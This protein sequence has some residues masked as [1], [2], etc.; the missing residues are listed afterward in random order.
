LPCAACSSLVFASR[1]SAPGWAGAVAATA[2]H[3]TAPHAQ[4]AEH[5][6]AGDRTATAGGS[7]HPAVASRCKCLPSLVVAWDGADENASGS[8]LAGDP[9]QFLADPHAASRSEASPITKI[10]ATLTA[11]AA[12]L[13]SLRRPRCALLLCSARSAPLRSAQGVLSAPL[14]SPARGQREREPNSLL[15]ANQRSSH[16]RSTRLTSTFAYPPPSPSTPSVQP[17]SVRILGRVP[18][19]SLKILQKGLVLAA[20]APGTRPY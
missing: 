20:T 4:E 9:L 13:A 6:A 10:A 18:N 3:S 2:Q 11:V 5:D 7:A 1:P 15:A 17:L 12:C 14:L 19:G 16:G 8:D